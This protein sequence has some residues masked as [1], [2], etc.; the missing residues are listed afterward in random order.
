MKR[1]IAALL[2]LV[3]L[4]VFTFGLVLGDK[5]PQ[6]GFSVRLEEL[7]SLKT[8][9]GKPASLKPVFSAGKTGEEERILTLAS[10]ITAGLDTEYA[11]L[12]AVYDW[13]TTNIDYDAEKA[14]NPAA[15]G[16]GAIYALNYRRGVCHDY[17]ELALAL[18]EASGLEAEY[19]S[20]EVVL[21][22]GKT[23]LHAWNEAVAGDVRYGLDTTW[24]AGFMLEDK[25]VFVRMP[26]DIYLTSP[27]KLAR[28]HQD[29]LYKQEQEEAFLK[30]SSALKEAVLMPKQEQDLLAFFNHF[31]E[32]NNLNS[33]EEEKP[34]VALARQHAE[35]YAEAV[36]RDEEVDLNHLADDLGEAAPKIGARSAGM[37]VLIRWLH[38]GENS[39]ETAEDVLK[40]LA[41]PLSDAQW[42][43][44]AIG[45]VR[46]G[47]LL[48]IVNLFLE[49]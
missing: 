21:A 33:L 18:L 16:S 24:G 8:K 11:K 3:T 41:A 4:L 2:I 17:A 9:A 29:P 7:F 14:A 27:Q 1:L 5:E 46:K 44:L 45:M 23:E 26:R 13:I 19:L 30:K 28:L 43:T 10:E 47:E 20:G 38:P 49:H 42:Q 25:S 32:E 34:L 37:Y 48:V 31:R 6:S 39:D 35:D 36:C 22:E 15:F 40:E 12:E